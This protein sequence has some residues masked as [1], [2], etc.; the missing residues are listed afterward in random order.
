MIRWTTSDIPQQ[1]GRS[2]VITGTGGLGF[3]DALA[4]A[5]AGADVTIAGRNPAKG[6]AALKLIR[7]AV[8]DAHIQFEEVDLAR[9]DSVATFAERLRNSRARL[10]IL[11]NNAA[12]M[13]PP[14]RQ[15]TADRF[16][17]Q[18]GTNYLGHFAL[19]AQLLPLLQNGDAP[20]VINL[21]SVAA[22]QGIIDFDD[23]QAERNYKP[24]PVYAQSKLAEPAFLL[25][26][27]KGAAQL[28]AGVLPV[29]RPIRASRV[30][31]C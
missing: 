22:R 8:P 23:L 19:T 24:M 12:V 17:L 16:E 5:R 3:Q 6:E 9:L 27:S 21:S 25:S 4:L 11:I 20:R 2:V 14:Q 15:T 1:N 7:A 26:S 13:T 10:D 29:S 30:P 31:T 28:L 18:F